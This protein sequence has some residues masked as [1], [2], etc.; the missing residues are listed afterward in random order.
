[1]SPPAWWRRGRCCCTE[2]STTCHGGSPTATRRLT[3]IVRR[4]LVILRSRGMCAPEHRRRLTPESPLRGREIRLESIGPSPQMVE[5][6]TSA[7][8]IQGE[9]GHVIAPKI[10]QP[11]AAWPMRRDH[12]SGI[13]SVGLRSWSVS[14]VAGVC[15]AETRTARAPAPDCHTWTCTISACR[16]CWYP[17]RA[18]HI[19]RSV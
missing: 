10:G 5:P 1:M 17:G 13:A 9:H 3:Y 18:N 7:R 4:G 6:A 2:R 12:D 8:D 16:S 11:L 15:V 14:G 19:R